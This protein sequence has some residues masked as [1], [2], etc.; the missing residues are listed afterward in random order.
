MVVDAVVEDELLREEVPDWLVVVD[1]LRVLVTLLVMGRDAV[2]VVD[3]VAL[4]DKLV[5]KEA[6][7]V[8]ESD[9]VALMVL[10]VQSG[11]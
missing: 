8:V 6:V 10:Q 4:I 7:V 3:V 1:A 11:W 2:G 9:R 5:V